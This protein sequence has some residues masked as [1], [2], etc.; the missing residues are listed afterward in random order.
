[1]AGLSGGTLPI[2]FAGVIASTLAYNAGYFSRVGV[3]KKYCGDG[4][5]LR[6]MRAMNRAPGT[7]AGTAWSRIRPRI[8][9]RQTI[10]SVSATGCTGRKIPGLGRTRCI[11]GNPSNEGPL[12]PRVV[13]LRPGMRDIFRELV[14]PGDL[15]AIGLF[16]FSG[17]LRRHCAA[18]SDALYGPQRSIT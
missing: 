4:L 17:V 16:L 14:S 5:Q 1:M 3:L 2:A 11:G 18:H 9:P 15:M 13:V 7:M 10:S 12:F 6:L 8:S